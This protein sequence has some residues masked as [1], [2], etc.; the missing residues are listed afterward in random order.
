MIKSNSF[1]LNLRQ[2]NTIKVIQP[3]CLSVYASSGMIFV[4]QHNKTGHMNILHHYIWIIKVFS[5]IGFLD[6][7]AP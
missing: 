5:S 1:Q 7:P 6:P 3:L 4:W 2:T